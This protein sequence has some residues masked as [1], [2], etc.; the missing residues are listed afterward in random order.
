MAKYSSLVFCVS[1]ILACTFFSKCD[2]TDDNRKLHII[3]MGSLPNTPYSP[4]SHHLSM[5]QQVFD[6]ND[7]THSLIHS[8]KRSFNGFA[9]MLTNEQKEKLSHMEGVVSVFPSRN[10]ELHTTRSWDF[11]GLT[12]SSKRSHA[13]ESDIVVGVLDTGVWP[14]SDSFKDEGF[15][16]IPKHWKGACSGGK[17]FTCNKKIIGARYY[18]D[19]SARDIGGHGT[20]T[21]STAAGNHIPGA[22]FY[23]L[24]EGTA[25]GGAPSARIAAYKVCDKRGCSGAAVMSAFDDAIADGVNIIS[26]SLG[27]SFQNSFDEDPIAIGSFHAMA[28]GILTV[29]SA[30]N[31]GPS[32]ASVSSIAPW[33]ITVAASTIDR[34]FIDKVVLGNGKTLIGIS[35]NSF[36]LNGTKALIA[37]KN[38][39]AGSRE[40]PQQDSNECNYL[41]R[42]LVKGKIVICDEISYPNYEDAQPIGSIIQDYSSQGEVSPAF[43]TPLPSLLLQPIEYEQLKSYTYSNKIPKAEILKSETTRDIN[44]PK[45]ADFSSRGPNKIAPEIMKPDITGPGVDILA[46]FSPVASPSGDTFDK[47][48]AKYNIISGTSMS[49]PHVTGIAA[50]VK[51][52]HLDW[53]PS[54]IKSA[55]MTSSKP[56]KGSTYDVGEYAYGSGHVNPISATHPGLVY[57]IS[58]DDYIQMLCNLG[59]DNKKVK[60]I[61]GKD[62]ACSKATHRSLVRDLN[63]PA[64]AIG[65]NSTTSFTIKFKRTVTN[66]GLA[67]SIYRATIFPNPKIKI[68]V[69]PNSLSFKSVHEKKSFVVTIAG[70]KLPVQTI[71]S[72]L[73]W[74]NSNYNVRSPIVIDICN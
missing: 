18:T 31:N 16:P 34:K 29:N 67:N 11:L 54:A 5:L 57:D 21:A 60:A 65:V 53:S 22:S 32:P 44:A 69:V 4:N 36:S 24:A 50:Y 47:R 68:T 40:Y 9:A 46:S 19:T 66:V 10:L 30:G 74:S 17:N 13:T 15:S 3:Y 70:D 56:M 14:E 39:R 58:L 45:V 35:V 25:R 12:R 26:V 48:A 27:G 55:L 52:F 20:H 37:K 72:S 73:I 71:T 62:N 64:L 8:F 41:D 51:S 49:C 33:M 63:Y 38:D 61:S 42:S 7:A 23:G 2:A 43:V 59:Y 1:F 28:K 6:G